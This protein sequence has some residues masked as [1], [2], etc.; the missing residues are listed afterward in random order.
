M[1]G[2][3]GKKKTYMDDVFSTQLYKGTGSGSHAINNGLDLSSEGGLVWIKSRTNTASNILQDTVNGTGKFIKSN[4]DDGTTNTSQYITSFNNNGYTLGT[5]NDINNSSQNFASWSFRKAPGFF[6]VVEWDGDGNSGRGISHS[7]GC[8]PGLIMIKETTG[9]Q[10][11]MVYHKSKGSGKYGVLSSTAAWVS[12]NFMDDG[13]DPTSTTFYLS[14]HDYV[15]GSSKSYIAYVFAGGE[16]T[17]ATAKSVEFDGDDYLKSTNSDTKFT[18][19]T[20]DF[21]VECWVKADNHNK[22]IFQISNT[23]GGLDSSGYQSD[24]SLW[25]HSDGRLGCALNGSNVY[26]T[27]KLAKGHWH[28]VAITRASGTAY[29]FLDGTLQ[30]SGS[31]PTDYDGTYLIISGY[32]STS[33]LMD[34]AISNFRVVKGQALY[35]SSFRPPIEPLTTTSQGATASNVSVLCCQGPGNPDDRASGGVH[36]SVD[37]NPTLRTDSPFDDPAGFV[38]GDAGENVIKCGSYVGTGSNLQDVFL[39]FEPQWVMIKCASN[40]GGHT[41]WAIYDSMRGVVSNGNDRQLTANESEAEESGDNYANSDLIEFTSTGFKVGQ[42]GWDVNHNANETYIYTAIRRPDGYCG[43]PYGAGEG[44]SVFAMDT[45]NAQATIPCLDSN[46]IV[47]FALLK[48]P[49]ASEDWSA[50]ARLISGRYLIP[51]TTAAGAAGADYSWDSN[52]GWGKGLNS[53]NQSWMWKRHAGMDVVTYTG[54]GATQAQGGQAIKHSLSKTPEMI[55]LKY[56]ND[57]YAWQVYHKGLNGGTTPQNYK[58]QLDD[59]AAESGNAAWW[60][61]TAPTS[62]HFTVGDSTKV[63]Y[64]NGTYIA[65]LFASVSGIS[66]VG[67]YTGTGSTQTITTGFQPRF[68]V[69]RRTDAGQYWIVM[70]TTRGWASGNDQTLIFNEGDAQTSYNDLGA[71]TS[72]GFTLTSDLNNSNASSGKYIYYA[73]A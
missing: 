73:H 16:S 36:M 5:D 67:Y 72:T 70:D 21:T 44:T 34:G 60:N 64:N 71:P 55:W 27:G 53:A 46:F 1:L 35:T 48:K 41:N 29:I 6:D 24:I 10:Q 8:V 11:W 42:S 22:G 15:N 63:N 56:R 9:T 47:D 19:G 45:S 51:N 52:V 61:N 20:G 37:G 69:I 40:G 54:N 25:T 30:F 2:V 39:G 50:S 57:A 26:G 68:V 12:S 65:M 66:K 18:M 4:S 17:A 13:I 49:S 43:K 3:G 23:S 33:F 59:E 7:L 38:F 31:E 32:Y 14:G 58:L 62:T 28:H